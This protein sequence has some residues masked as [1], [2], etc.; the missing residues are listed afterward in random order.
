M[1]EM[2]GTGSI[3][4]KE[5]TPLPEGLHLVSEPY[6]KGWRLVKNPDGCG[7]DRKLCEAG[8][9]FFYMAEEVKATSVGNNLEET[10]RRA[11]KKVIAS[12]ESGKLNCIEITQVAAK[13][14]L[15]R[16]YVAVTV[17][18][19]HIQESVVLFHAKHLAEWERAKLA[20][21]ST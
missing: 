17:H 3:L 14:F 1:A 6:S 15:R 4:I 12:M 9:N 20:A 5:G 10:T 21:V 7:L 16:P 8:W 18:P 19:R 13:R 11:V 2:I